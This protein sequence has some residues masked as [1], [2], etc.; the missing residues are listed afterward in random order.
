MAARHKGTKK[1]QERATKK[2]EK[3]KAKSKKIKSLEAKLK[4]S[5]ARNEILETEN[6]ALKICLNG[7]H[8]ANHKYSDNVI[9]LCIQACIFCNISYRAASKLMQSLAAIQGEVKKRISPST[10]RNWCLRYGLSKLYKEVKSGDY[11]LIMDESVTI[12]Q[13]VLL[14]ILLVP[15]DGQQSRIS[16]LEMKDTIVLF[17]GSAKSWKSELVSQIIQVKIAQMGLNIKYAVTDNCPMLKKTLVKCGI[18]RLLDITHMIANAVK[19]LYAKDEMFNNFIKKLN[20]TRAKWSKSQY[21][22]FIPPAIRKKAR[23]HQLLTVYEWAEMILKNWEELPKGA[24]DELEYVYANKELI[25][26]MKCLQMMVSEYCKVFKSIGISQETEKIWNKRYEKNCKKEF[27]EQA[28]K[29]PK[30]LMFK[31][32]LE[33]YITTTVTGLG[34]NTEA[35]ICTSDVIE[36]MFGKYKHQ[37]LQ[38]EITD[39]ILKIPIYAGDVKIEDIAAA[40]R[41]I[42]IKELLLWKK[43]NTTDS[44]KVIRKKMNK[45]KAA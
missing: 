11:V 43:E 30:L 19:K 35:H 22:A 4:R 26:S 44:L 34:D 27:D 36:S 28:L 16:P 20:L 31:Q 23:F 24:K 2:R 39:D 8:V 18:L 10:I 15:I 12:G 33:N 41:L 45:K 21:V 14:L 25:Q 5:L 37:G 1:E 13:Q 38:K 29:D 17:V 7:N 3:E 40:F 32:I 9:F 6:K 42:S